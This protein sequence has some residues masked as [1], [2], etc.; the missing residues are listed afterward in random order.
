MDIA[1][2]EVKNFRKLQSCRIELSKESTIFVGANNSGKTS[3]MLALIKFLKNRQLLLDD[4]TISNLPQ[5]AAIGASYADESN[6][7]V[8]TISDWSAVLPSLDVW[9]NVDETE[10]RYIANI[11]P[12]LSWNGGKI[13]IRLIF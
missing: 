1:F 2:V 10:V 9:L 11:I 7:S 12:T 3:A 13:G 4:F 5:I 8:P 6:T